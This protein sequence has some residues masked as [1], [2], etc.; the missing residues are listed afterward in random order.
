[1]TAHEDGWQEPPVL[2][3]APRN[4]GDWGTGAARTPGRREG[5]HVPVAG[6]F[7]RESS[8]S[9]GSAWAAASQTLPAG[10]VSG[11]HGARGAVFCFPHLPVGRG[12]S[13]GVLRA[14]VQGGDAQTAFRQ[15]LWTRRPRGSVA[16]PSA[17]RLGNVAVKNQLKRDPLC[18]KEQQRT[19]NTNSK[20]HARG[21]SFAHP[22]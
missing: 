2:P 12:L 4:L 18:E 1:M 9:Q 17:L 21:C 14:V 13:H 20:T 3:R 5:L 11:H 16:S 22:P 7:S 6:C 19:P 8:T 10:G 15:R